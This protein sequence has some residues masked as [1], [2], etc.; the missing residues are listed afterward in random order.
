MSRLSENLATEPERLS[1]VDC[2]PSQHRSLRR[3][4]I[5]APH[6]PKFSDALYGFLCV[7][8]T[9][10]CVLVANPF[11]GVGFN[12][13]WSYAQVALK[14]ADTGYIK[15]NG[16]APA[17]QLIQALWGGA[18]IRLFGFSFNLLRLITLP[19]SIGFVWLVYALGRASGL[20]AD[21]SCFGALVVG[22]SPLYVP[23]AASFMTE[24]Y[25]CFFTAL[26]LFA[27][28]RSAEAAN[29]KSAAFWLWT[30]SV[31]GIVGGSDRQSVWAAPL[32]LI[33]YLWWIRRS[34]RH[35]AHHAIGA[36]IT[37]LGLIVLL[38]TQYTQP[39][40]GLDVPREQIT[41]ILV[42]NLFPAPGR[43]VGLFL[44]CLQVVWPALLCFVP[45]WKRLK[46][47]EVLAAAI[48]SATLVFFSILACAS[49]APFASSV[50]SG[51]GLLPGGGDGL[52]YRPLLLPTLLR[53]GLGIL[54]AFSGLCVLASPAHPLRR[55]VRAVFGISCCAYIPVLIPG[56]ITGFVHD[57]YVLP[58]IPAIVIFALNRFQGY[59][60]T[61]PKAA[62][63][64]LILLAVYGVV[65]THD[66]ASASRARVEAAAALEARGIEQKYISAGLEY[67]AWTQLQKAGKVAPIR[68]G[69]T[70]E[71]NGTDRFWLWNY[72]KYLSPEYVAISGKASNSADG[73]LP[74]VAFTAWAPPFRRA[75]IVARRENLPKAKACV[76]RQPCS[77]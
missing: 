30:L 69:D 23:L 73:E 7:G 61:I 54:I 47:S 48:G 63:A 28:I 37:T 26:C 49:A 1:D 44:A 75:V 50:L 27:A 67:D 60:R 20:R 34:D 46:R 53:I 18:W 17:M 65:I 14:F 38:V 36:F 15:Y 66:Y 13:D 43:L 33:P 35:F 39:Y 25:S 55:H 11:C 31:A 5:W 74:K 62:W 72:A 12:D 21:L 59:G 41:R 8:I 51:Y 52:G 57:R 76:M 3:A 2:V 22:T 71:W 19:F 10:A 58:L 4:G 64:C 45:F 70:F 42:Q 6:V 32:A 9:L 56:A 68:Y 24:P 29:T 77:F 16:W 40:P